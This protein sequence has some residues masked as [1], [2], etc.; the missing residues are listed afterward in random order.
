MINEKFKNL[1]RVAEITMQPVPTGDTPYTMGTMDCWRCETEVIVYSWRGK[2]WMDDNPP[3]D[4]APHTIEYRYSRKAQGSYWAN[5][6]PC[7]KV[8]Q[9]ENFIYEPRGPLPHP[10]SHPSRIL[11]ILGIKRREDNGEAT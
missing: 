1:M 10:K 9:G 3:P 5:V 7:C 8:I 2:T 6:C 4:P 11:R